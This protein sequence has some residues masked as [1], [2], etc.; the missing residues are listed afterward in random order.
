MIELLRRKAFAFMCSR[1]P[2]FTIRGDDRPS[3]DMEKPYLHRWY[4]IPR[5][6]FFNIYIHEFLRS[7][8]DGALHDHPW[9]NLSILV[10]GAYR[11]HTI[12]KGGINK[13]KLRRTGTLSG[14]KFRSPWSAHRVELLTNAAMGLPEMRG[15]KQ[16]TPVYTIF[17]T[18]P[19]LRR[20][21]FHCRLGWR[22]FELFVKTTGDGNQ[23]GMGCG[24]LE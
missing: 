12:A 8:H 1:P 15:V 22:D 11:E 2:D 18:G 5:N 20:W 14:I 10:L 17:I 21:G 7:D 13:W 3:E 6:R 19:K 23:K 9:F 16:E 24:E 4:A